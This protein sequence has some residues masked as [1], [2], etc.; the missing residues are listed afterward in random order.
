MLRW[1]SR[2]SLIGFA[3]AVA[4]AVYLGTST[5][6]DFDRM[7]PASPIDFVNVVAAGKSR[8]TAI[9]RRPMTGQP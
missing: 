6:M 4:H 1:H 8:S 7:A 2:W 9:R 5:L 3:L